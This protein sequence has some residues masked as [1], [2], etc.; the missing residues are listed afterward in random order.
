M[1]S[2][3]KGG[4]PNRTANQKETNKQR[5]VSKQQIKRNIERNKYN[6]R[7][8]ITK[9]SYLLPSVDDNQATTSSESDSR[10]HPRGKQPVQAK[11]QQ[12]KNTP[13]KQTTLRKTHILNQKIHAYAYKP[14][15][16][17]RDLHALTR[18]IGPGHSN[19]SEVK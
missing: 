15:G 7:Q 2:S 1:L 5:H 19:K 11:L 17:R 3:E 12:T 13:N 14:N 10:Q 8:R 9:A 16:V 18:T 6:K 4:S